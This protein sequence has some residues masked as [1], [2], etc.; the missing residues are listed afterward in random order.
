MSLF[1]YEK[2]RGIS[3]LKWFSAFLVASISSLKLVIMWIFILI[4]NLCAFKARTLFNSFYSSVFTFIS[5]LLFF[6]SKISI[7]SSSFYYSDWPPIPRFLSTSSLR[8][9]SKRSRSD[10]LPS[11][12]SSLYSEIELKDL[13]KSISKKRVSI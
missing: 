5:S 6:L 12:F 13:S 4:K 1:R 3:V 7:T 2:R 11:D 9:S 8:A 10:S